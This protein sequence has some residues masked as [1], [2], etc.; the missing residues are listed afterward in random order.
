[1]PSFTISSLVK[2]EIQEVSSE[3]LTMK[4]VNYE[5][6]PLIRMSMPPDHLSKS[7]VKWPVGSVIFTSTVF[8]FGIIPVDKHKFRLVK[9]DQF[10]IEERSTAL[11]NLE[12]NHLRQI[13]HT[14]E[15]TEISDVVEFKPI[16]QISGYFMLP[17]YKSIFKHR[18]KRIMK[19]YAQS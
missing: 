16:L 3:L 2:K 7:I 6:M 12:W 4:G 17:I 1:M 14:N 9:T 11:S 15:H 10:G 8:L 19:K 13:T 18:H 5:L